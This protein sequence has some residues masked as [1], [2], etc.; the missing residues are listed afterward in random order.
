MSNINEEYSR[1]RT[2]IK[3]EEK[4]GAM[5]KSIGNFLRVELEPKFAEDSEMSIDCYVKNVEFFRDS[6]NMT[7][8]SKSFGKSNGY[9]MPSFMSGFSDAPKQNTEAITQVIEWAKQN[10]IIEQYLACVRRKSDYSLYIKFLES[11]KSKKFNKMIRKNYN[12]NLGDRETQLFFEY[13]RKEIRNKEA[14]I[15]DDTFKRYKQKDLMRKDADKLL[16]LANMFFSSENNRTVMAHVQEKYK[17]IV[18]VIN[19]SPIPLNEIMKEFPVFETENDVLNTF[20]VDYDEENHYLYAN[21]L[22]MIEGE[23][24]KISPASKNVR[25]K[26]KEEVKTSTV[27]KEKLTV[28]NKAVIVKEEIKSLL[29]YNSQITSKE[30]VDISTKANII[31]DGEV[32]EGNKLFEDDDLNNRSFLFKNVLSPLEKIKKYA[33]INYSSRIALNRKYY[34]SSDAKEK[35]KAKNARDQIHYFVERGGLRYSQSLGIVYKTGIYE[36]IKTIE[37]NPEKRFFVVVN[38]AKDANL[39]ED[40]EFDNVLV[41]RIIGFGNEKK[42]QLTNKSL[43]HVKPFARYEF[44][45]SDDEINESIEQSQNDSVSV[46]VSKEPESTQQKNESDNETKDDGASETLSQNIEFQ[47]EEVRAEAKDV[48]SPETPEHPVGDGDSVRSD[49]NSLNEVPKTASKTKPSKLP[50][51]ASVPCIPDNDE[52]IQIT[53]LPNE[54]SVLSTSSGG[55]VVLSKKIGEGGEG[56]IYE[57]NNDLVAKI[58]HKNRLTQNRFD[59]LNLMIQCGFES[60]RVCFPLELLFD[61]SD[62][63][64]GYTMKKAPS[65]YMNIGESIL[66]LNNKSALKKYIDLQKW[67][68]LALTSFCMNLTDIFGNLHDNNILMGDINAGNILV[69]IKDNSGA[70]V[71]IVDTDSFQIGPYPCPVGTPVFTSPEIYKRTNEQYPR[72]GNFLRTL[73]DEQYA[74]AS[75][76]FQILFLGQTPFAGKGVVGE[77]IDALKSYNFDYRGENSTGA[78]VPDGPF[79]M[80]WQNIGLKIKKMFEDTFT[81]KKTYSAKQWRYE[82]KV[83]AKNIENGKSDNLL[84]PYRYPS[85]PYIKEFVCDKCKR[86]ANLPEDQYE[87]KIMYKELLL[88]KE[89]DQEWLRTVKETMVDAT[90]STCGKLFK[91]SAYNVLRQQT[92]GYLLKCSD[93]EGVVETKCCRCGKPITVQRYKYNNPKYNKKFRCDKCMMDLNIERAID[94]SDGYFG[95]FEKIEIHEK[96]LEKIEE[97][98]KELKRKLSNEELEE[99]MDDVISN[100]NNDDDEDYDY[101]DDEDDDDNEND[102]E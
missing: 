13:I 75:L 45:N 30:I 2:V 76:L 43:S 99:I 41:A 85:R 42:L 26:A 61:S 54:G 65:N 66:Q 3:F 8:F 32:F 94:N 93:C 24:N 23:A 60:E 17:D 33:I 28:V 6:A 5:L 21:S 53:T 48:A 72:Y 101:E 25:A 35:N 70:S 86:P 92:K 29:E 97:S 22:K 52:K 63:F 62:K 90:C 47:I 50:K 37:A 9:E 36:T 102:D 7:I 91:A 14:H 1:E 78:D 87:K 27:E 12:V 67:D 4:L 11:P 51:I 20:T 81:G 84:K 68:R 80:I 16:K 56:S 49:D 69:D 73:E 46:E 74:L 83:Y 18:E 98:E 58:Y 39:I 44:L 89:C 88:C 38:S 82:L 31:L 71:L 55:V 57:I 95:D 59:K 79:R 10:G 96:I 15:N 34:E 100:M 64:V 77:G 40:N 19:S